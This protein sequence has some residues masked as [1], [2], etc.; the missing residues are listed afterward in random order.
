MFYV[1]NILLLYSEIKPN[2]CYIK[3][4]KKR[5]GEIISGY[6]PFVPRDPLL[7]LPILP[8]H[9]EAGPQQLSPWAPYL[10][11]FWMCSVNGKWGRRLEG[12]T[13]ERFLSAGH[14][15]IVAQVLSCRSQPLF[16]GDR[17]PWLPL[18]TVSTWSFRHRP[19]GNFPLFTPGCFIIPFWPSSTLPSPFVNST[20]TKQSFTPFGSAIYFLLGPRLITDLLQKLYKA[21]GQ[22]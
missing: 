9:R 6:F 13:K 7:H 4:Q 5:E 22:V 19:G 11:G 14:G 12:R 21:R 17:F 15:L 18:A 2:I 8:V 10:S 16:L 1:K 20:S 3:Q